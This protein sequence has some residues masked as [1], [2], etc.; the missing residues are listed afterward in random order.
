VKGELH[1]PPMRASPGL[2]PCSARARPRKAS[3]SRAKNTW[4]S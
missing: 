2:S 4:H 1:R 3:I